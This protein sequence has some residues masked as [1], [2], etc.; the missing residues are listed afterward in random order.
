MQ[1]ANKWRAAYNA[2]RGITMERTVALLE[3]GE[4]GEMADLQWAFRFAEKRNATCRALIQ[5]RTAALLK[6]D[7]DIKVVDQL[8]ARATESMAQ[9]QQQTLRAWYERIDNLRGALRHL[10]L[11]EFR[12]YSHLQIQTEDGEAAGWDAARQAAGRLRLHPLEQWHWVR[13]GL[14]TGWGWNPDAS[15]RGWEGIPPEHR[16]DPRAWGLVIRECPMALD[17]LA[18]VIYLRKAL[19]QKDWDA[20]IEIYGIPGGVA[21]MPPGVPEGDATSYETAAKE[22]AE[23][24]SGALPH[25]S[26]YHANDGPRGTNP[27]RDHIRYQDEELV[28]AGTGG[29]LTMLS[30][31]GSG[32]LAG[33]AHQD[34]FDDLAEAEAAEISEVMQRQFDRVILEVEHPGEPECAYWELA[35]EPNEDTGKLVDRIVKLHGIGFRTPVEEVAER[36]GLKLELA[37]APEPA[38]P[39]IPVPAVERP[40]ANSARPGLLEHGARQLAAATQADLAPLLRRLAAIEGIQDPE[41]RRARLEALVADWDGLA[42]DIL[43]DPEAAQALAR[44]MGTATANG[45]AGQKP[46]ANTR[47]YER[48]HLGRFASDGGPLGEADNLERGG[49]AVKHALRHLRDVPNAMNVAGLGQVDFVW[50]TPGAKRDDFKGGFGLSHMRAKHGDDALLKLPMTLAKGRIS[51][52]PKDPEKRLV[53]FEGYEAVVVK[54]KKKTSWTLTHFQRP[55]GP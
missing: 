42:G 49:N 7:W 21:I 19:S 12:G 41:I 15:S 34:A 30:E 25:G 5:R 11:A 50:G 43:A 33:E 16:V 38:T 1:K 31:S 17:E 20:F 24:G 27:F 6:L 9:A 18:L 54:E 4:R 44:V 8:P 47:S 22:V 26:E 29:K 23:G 55:G 37:P 32:T 40:L 53:H 36:T 35:A 14:E 46:I 13:D 28:L 45:L 2:L 39:E 48:D 3:A 10:A 52:H 51:P